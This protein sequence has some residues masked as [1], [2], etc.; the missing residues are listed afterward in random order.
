V[1]VL[2]S[3]LDPSLRG[4]ALAAGALAF[5]DKAEVASKLRVAIADA[6]REQK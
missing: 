3:G 2:T 6:L 4:R 1:I 5:I